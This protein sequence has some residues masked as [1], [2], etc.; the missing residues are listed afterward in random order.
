[1]QVINNDAFAGCESLVSVEIPDSVTKIW[2]AAF[3]RCSNLIYVKLPKSL[4]EI[5]PFVFRK[6]NNLTEI[7]LPDA[8]EVIEREA[9]A[10][11]EK[12]SNIYIPDSVKSIDETSFSNCNS[13]IIY[14]SADSYAYEYLNSQN[15]PVDETTVSDATIIVDTPICYYTG[16]EICPDITVKLDNY[17]LKKDVDYNVSY[18][19]NIELG[20]ATI[21]VEGIGKFTGQNRTEF[22]IKLSKYDIT[23]GASVNINSSSLIY[24]GKEI[25]PD[26]KVEY[27]DQIMTIGKDYTITYK[28]NIYPGK[29]TIVITGIGDYCGTINIGFIITP[30]KVKGLKQQKKYSKKYI[31]LLWDKIDGVDGYEVY[32]SDSKNGIYENVKSV[33]KSIFKNSG[34]KSGK[35]YYY[36]IIAYKLVDGEKIY[37]DFSSVKKMMTAPNKPSLKISRIKDDKVKLTWKK[38]SG[39]KGYEIHMKI[40]A[41]GKYKKIKTLSANKITFIKNN[42]K[43]N[44]KY[45][46]KIRA[47]SKIGK[48]KVYS[49]WSKVKNVNY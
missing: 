49:S 14:C 19:N 32:R 20:T 37:G 25:T 8:L 46:F 7:V 30:S 36:K 23:D 31:S 42:L 27:N 12:L 1:M 44:K 11:C 10:D 35:N 39:A 43:S 33:S 48:N 38:V 16:D 26:V 13:L 41:K 9:F 18:I 4:T 28:N 22:T 40:G 45:S 29:A 2:S 21:I 5:D 24:I 34:I 15:I 3:D 47:Y 17:T 6:C